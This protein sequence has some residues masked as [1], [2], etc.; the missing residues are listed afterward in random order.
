MQFKIHKEGK[1]YFIISMILTIIVI[2]FSF[3]FGIILFIF[4]IYIF[5]FFRNP[6]RYIPVEDIIVSPADGVITYIG[7]CKGPEKLDN[8]K[9]IKISIFLNIFNVHVNRIPTDGEIKK[10]KYIHG[11]FINATLDKSSKDNERNIICIENK[12]K[13][14]IYVTQIAGMI[15][16]R[17]ICDIRENQIVKK[18][19]RFGII[20]F[21]SR[22]DL[23]LPEN[24]K[25]MVSKGQIVV[26]GET[27]IANPNNINEIKSSIKN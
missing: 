15:A 22:V 3:I 1:I 5:Y 6:T 14:I 16:R 20:K 12:N 8:N 17:I 26:G 11:K 2:P 23:Y 21:G 9:F 27:M 25:I 13:E 4:S 19:D 7:P 24:Y 10:I 18:G